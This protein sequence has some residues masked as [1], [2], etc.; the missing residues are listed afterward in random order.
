MNPQLDLHVEL[1]WYWEGSIKRY[2]TELQNWRVSR[3]IA[4]WHLKKGSAELLW[5]NG[6]RTVEAGH[7]IVPPPLQHN[8]FF[9]S[10]AEVQS[11]RLNVFGPD[12][13]MLICPSEPIVIPYRKH[14]ALAQHLVNLRALLSD[15][16]KQDLRYKLFLDEA[17]MSPKTQIK[18]RSCV[19][20]W[21]GALMDIAAAD[22]IPLSE[23]AQH[24][25]LLAALHYLTHRD[26]STPLR[27]DKLARIAGISVTHL[28]R[29]FRKQMGITIKEWDAQHLDASVKQALRSGRTPC[30]EIAYA[31]G[32]S[33]GSHFSRWFRKLHGCT[34]NEWRTLKRTDELA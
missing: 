3:E 30:K 7:W 20:Q 16:L 18:L 28:R 33:S 8:E 17:E 31:H 5:K 9:S 26:M 14:D 13:N 15:D 23:P 10:D 27:E 2:Y 24:P 34:P 21:V 32:F 11:L 22:S 12:R 19:S 6:R 1:L 4:C 25:S 29:L